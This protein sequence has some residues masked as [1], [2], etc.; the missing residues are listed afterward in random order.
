MRATIL[1]LAS[2]LLLRTALAAQPGHRRLEV[3][4]LDGEREHTLAAFVHEG[5]QSV[6][7][8]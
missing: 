6:V 4:H 8:R 2:A 5:C 7:W 1:T 3:I